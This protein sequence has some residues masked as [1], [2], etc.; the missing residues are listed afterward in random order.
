MGAVLGLWGGLGLGH[1]QLAGEF[2]QQEGEFDYLIGKV[3]GPLELVRGLARSGHQVLGSMPCPA[4][5]S[6]G[7][8]WVLQVLHE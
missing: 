6:R 4:K 5:D 8:F 1:L 3:V 7:G 2:V